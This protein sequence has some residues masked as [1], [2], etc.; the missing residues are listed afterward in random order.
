MLH[1][2]CAGVDGYDALTSGDY[3]RQRGYTTLDYRRHLP[4]IDLDI[5]VN[6]A[7]RIRVNVN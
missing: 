5:S 3:T 4:N 1:C 7:F 2:R 6:A